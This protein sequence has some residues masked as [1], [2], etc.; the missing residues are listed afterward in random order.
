[1]RKRQT[2]QLFSRRLQIPVHRIENQ[3]PALM[4]KGQKNTVA[5][6]S[7]HQTA[8]RYVRLFP[9]QADQ[10]KLNC[11][12]AG[13]RKT[14]LF[15]SIF[16]HMRKMKRF[17]YPAF[18]AASGSISKILPISISIPPPNA[19]FSCRVYPCLFLK[20]RYAHNSL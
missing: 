3:F 10:G 1:M 15:F 5:H 2:K 9:F 12:P 4:Q 19:H 14:A 18:S 13:S 8:F 16:I 7:R 17:R 20:S 6:I 11:F